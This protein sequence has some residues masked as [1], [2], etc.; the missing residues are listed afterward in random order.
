MHALNAE[1]EADGAAMADIFLSYASEDRNRVRP[2]AEALQQ[3]GF[4]VWW[5]RSLA[6]GDDFSAVIQR[7]LNAAKAVIVVWTQT[8]AA[9]VWVRDEAGRARDDGR[10]VPVMLD[11]VQIPLGFGAFQAEDFSKWNGSATAAQMQLLEEALRAKLEGRGVDA[12]SVARRRQRLMSR[13]RIVSVLTVAAAVVG[14]AAGVNNLVNPRAPTVITDN[15]QQ[16]ENMAELLAL[17]REGKITPEQAIELSRILESQTFETASADASDRVASASPAPSAD[18]APAAEPMTDDAPGMLTAPGGE[19]EAAVQVAAITE[20][21]F[22]AAARETFRTDMTALLTHPDAGVRTAA[23]QLSNERTR[24]RA[25]QTLWTYAENNP[26]PTQAAIYRVCGAVGEAN[27]NPL[28]LRAL[29]RARALSP[30]DSNVWRMMSFGLQRQNRTQEAAGAALV[31]QGL[32]AQA[33]GNAQV[34]EERLQQALPA[35]QAPESRAFVEGQ[36]GDS[37]ARRQ[38]W[39]AAAERYEAAFTNRQRAAQTRAPAAAAQLDVDAQKLVRALDRSGQ[40][41]EACQAVERAR[42]AGVEETEAD[43]AR[44]C[45]SLRTVRPRTELRQQPQR[46]APRTQPSQAPY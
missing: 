29:E 8:S 24:D 13:I 18:S 25:M 3:R 43:V 14:I 36:L 23:L 17:V 33:Q 30:Q 21:Q 22:E 31:S 19:S 39:Q 12:A 10:L 46:V 16:Q 9:S 40:T 6:A 5:D 4:S 15:R 45:A 2:L 1:T 7:E 32:E 35:L 34:A 41:E 38:D 28:G 26:G 42:A 20:N 11:R 27:N 37:A 44:R